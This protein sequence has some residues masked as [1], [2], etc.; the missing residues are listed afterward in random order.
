MLVWKGE[1][2]LHRIRSLAKGVAD[3]GLLCSLQHPYSVL[4]LTLAL[5]GSNYCKGSHS[6][7]C[8]NWLSSNCSH[9]GYFDV[10]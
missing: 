6:F 3:V 4:K 2:S 10:N 1:V 5:S 7:T 9:N 8:G